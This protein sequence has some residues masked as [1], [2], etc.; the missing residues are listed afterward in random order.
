MFLSIYFEAM[1]FIILLK[2]K[3]LSP[4]KIQNAILCCLQKHSQI[5]GKTY[6][7]PAIQPCLMCFRLKQVKNI[8]FIT[9]VPNNSKIKLLKKPTKQ[10]VFS[11]HYNLH[12]CAN[13]DHVE[14]IF[15]HCFSRSSFSEFF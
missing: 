14:S 13:S 15:C 10:H 4:I 1:L 12:A 8:C 7:V 5:V 9:Y 3:K 2:S 6:I 11:M